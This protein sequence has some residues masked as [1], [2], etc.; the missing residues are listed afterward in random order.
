[1]MT[2]LAAHAHRIAVAVIANMAS[3][4]GWPG[5]SRFH[6]D[7]LKIISATQIIEPPMSSRAPK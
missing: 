4:T 1:M 2:P 7:M 5:L 3:G 6:A